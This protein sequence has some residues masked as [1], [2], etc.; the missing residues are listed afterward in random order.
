[1][2]SALWRLAGPRLASRLGV[3]VEAADILAFGGT[4][5][6]AAEGLERSLRA[7]P[8][9]VVAHGLAVP[10]AI[11]AASRVDLPWLLLSNGP[12]TKLD[13]AHGALAGLSSLP[14]GGEAL[15]RTLL[16]PGPWVSLL[17]SSLALRRTVVN[18][19][20]MDRDI[21]DALSG[22]LVAT[23]EG[24]R[25]IAGYWASLRGPLP[26]AASVR[27]PLALAWADEDA[28]HPA[29]GASALEARRPGTLHVR[30]PGARWMWPEERPWVLA[31][32]L[33]AFPPARDARSA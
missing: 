18:P 19:Y 32:V 10:A 8:R 24:R 9:G 20:A 25:A 30:V 15:S 27:S 33:E 14:G 31:D 12:L 16:R 22:S 4:W 11:A 17:A 13:P 5:E 1:M 23:A 21:V 3:D 2:S 6:A 7:R 29:S 26:D 28:L